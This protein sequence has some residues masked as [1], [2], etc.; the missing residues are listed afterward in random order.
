[1]KKDYYHIVGIIDR[2][3]SMLSIRDEVIG[4]FNNFI[5][6]QKKVEGKATMTLVQFDDEYLVNYEFIDIQ[7]VADLNNETYVPRGMTAMYDAIGK[8]IVNTGIALSNMDENNRPEKVIVII[9]TDG[10][11]NASQEY[12]SEVIKKMIKEQE[13]KYNWTFTFLGANINAKETANNIGINRKMSMTFAANSVGTSSAY[14]SVSENLTDVRCGTKLNMSYEDKDY[15]AQE[16]A[17][18]S[19]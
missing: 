14:N 10:Y 17:G 4:G 2:S 18:V 7:N 6:D 11:E 19:Q 15:S 1:L 5:R 3:G 8:T 9:Q 16:N 12:T 13:E